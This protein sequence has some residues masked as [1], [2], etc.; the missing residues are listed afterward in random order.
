M[1]LA[2]GTSLGGYEIIAPIGEGGMGE[3]YRAHDPRLSRD[4]ALK[5][6]PDAFAS[7][8]DRLTR[9]IREAQT[10]A[11]LNHPNIAQIHGLEE[12]A[13]AGSGQAG[14][15]ALVMELVEGDD[16]SR[17]IAH[18]AIPVDEAL[19]IAKQ[20]AEALEAAHEQGIIHRDLKPAN[21]KVRADGTVKVLDFGLAKAMRPATGPPAGTSMSPT[22]TAPAKTQVGMILGTAAYMSPE[23]AR[24]REVDKRADIW[25]FGCVLHEMLTG[26][27]LFAGDSLP[28]TLGL[29]FSRDPDLATLPPATPARV[30]A[31]IARCLVKDPRQRLRDIGEA[32]LALDGAHDAPLALQSAPVPAIRRSLPWTI[33]AAAS[34]VAGWA[35]WSRT[36]PTPTS[37]QLTHLDIGYQRDVQNYSADSLGPALSPDGR[38]AAIVGARDGVRRVFIRRLDR[39]AATELP[40]TEGAN[41]VVFSPDGDSVAV[42]FAS[43]LITRIALADQQRKVLTA[44]ADVTLSITWCPAGVI[45]GRSGALWMIR[46]WRARCQG[47]W[48]SERDGE[49]TAHAR[50]GA[51]ETAGVHREATPAASDR[52]GRPDSRSSQSSPS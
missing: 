36:G 26:A 24:G 33:A 5:I 52:A 16:L 28:E 43:G 17:R 23:Q 40:D 22:M 4:V 45:F 34:L 11:S 7:D 21:I 50:D 32:R 48:T 15:R 14:V 47:R 27:R 25:A 19:P 49:S 30:R 18:G 8:S 44:G 35:V 29:I 41:G 51:G 3:V 6:L 46:R 31:L 42:L 12:S 10:L 2:P 1:P 9:F 13:S 39:A 38:T 37:P 20:I